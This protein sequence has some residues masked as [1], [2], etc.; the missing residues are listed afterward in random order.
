VLQAKKKILV[1]FLEACRGR[2][3]TQD[4]FVHLRD[5]DRV[6]D[7]KNLSFFSLFFTYS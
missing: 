1:F 2:V 7:F 4:A 5:L 6:S 3:V